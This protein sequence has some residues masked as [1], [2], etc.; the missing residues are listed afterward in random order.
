[1]Q[2]AALVHCRSMTMSVVPSTMQTEKSQRYSSCNHTSLSTLLK[3]KSRM[4]ALTRDLRYRYL[5]DGVFI[6]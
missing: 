6:F 3:P 4:E 2:V 1:M 5:K